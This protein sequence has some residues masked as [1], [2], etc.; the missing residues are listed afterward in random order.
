MRQRPGWESHDGLGGGDRPDAGA[1][2]EAGGDVVHD[3]LQ[4]RSVGLECA[5][6]VVDGQGQAADLGVADGLFA[7][8]IARQATA[9]QAGERGVG[10]CGAGELAIGVVV[11]VAQ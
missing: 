6:G 3:G 4:L 5:A 2:G 7:A 1:V 9:G 11:G 8:G 10:E